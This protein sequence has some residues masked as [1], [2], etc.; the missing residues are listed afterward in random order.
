L[1]LTSHAYGL[2]GK[3]ICE[4]LCSG[5]TMSIFTTPWA[6]SEKNGSLIE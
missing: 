5:K 3:T 6:F 2:E 4:G 1:E